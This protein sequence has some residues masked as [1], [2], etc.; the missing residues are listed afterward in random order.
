VAEPPH[1]VAGHPIYF[2]WE[3]A[4]AALLEVQ[5]CNELGF[6]QVQFEGDAKV[7]VTIVNSKKPD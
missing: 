5:I 3:E 2:A 6:T 1:R 4:R 7:V